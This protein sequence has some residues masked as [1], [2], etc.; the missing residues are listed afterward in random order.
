MIYSSDAFAFLRTLTSF[1]FL[2]LDDKVVARDI[3]QIYFADYMYLCA[4]MF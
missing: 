3:L 4:L 2:F 1:N